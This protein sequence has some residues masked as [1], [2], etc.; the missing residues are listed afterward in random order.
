[1]AENLEDLVTKAATSGDVTTL[2]QLIAT[3]GAPAVRM[4][5]NPNEL[6]ALHWAAASGVLDAVN[7]LLSPAVQADPQAARSNN[8]TPLHSAAMRG[9]TAIRRNNSNAA[10]VFLGRRWPSF[11]GFARSLWI[12]RIVKPLRD[13]E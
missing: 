10:S 7:Y 4:D 13:V 5:G 11:P 12:E 6:T 3:H 1:M 2:T 9:H 8:F